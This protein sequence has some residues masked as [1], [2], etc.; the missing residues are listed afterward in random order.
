MGAWIDDPVAYLV[1]IL[2]LAFKLIGTAGIFEKEA[3]AV[4]KPLI[5]GTLSNIEKVGTVDALTGPIARGDAETVSRHLIDIMKKT[6]ELAD[7]Y[8]VLG[9]YTVDIARDKGLGDEALAALQ[10][11]LS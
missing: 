8:K 6:P 9:R 11:V 4:L 1:T 5:N 3:F 7:L 10:K 2:D